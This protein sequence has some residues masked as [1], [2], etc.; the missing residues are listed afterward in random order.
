MKQTSSIKSRQDLIKPGQSEM[1]VRKPDEAEQRAISAARLTIAEMA[2]RFEAAT[3]VETKNGATQIRQ[4]PKHSD[5]DGWR[6]Q[7]MVAFGT[8][9]ATV[10]NIELERIAKALRRKDGT[11]DP[12]ELDTV[13]A[14]VS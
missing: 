3:K 11:L 7:F 4:G 2:P 9:S 1:A 14:I 8:T 13:I 6:V 12:S 5:L 10:V